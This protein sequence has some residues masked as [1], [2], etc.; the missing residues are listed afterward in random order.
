L[1]DAADK[2]LYRAKASGKNRLS[3]FRKP[4]KRSMNQEEK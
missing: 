2:A 3:L 4:E 1:I